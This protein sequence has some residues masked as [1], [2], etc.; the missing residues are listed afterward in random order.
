MY[1]VDR[2]GALN[3]FSSSLPL[4]TIRQDTEVYFWEPPVPDSPVLGDQMICIVRDPDSNGSEI[5]LLG[6]DSAKR[7]ASYG[8]SASGINL[9]L[10]GLSGRTIIVS[11]SAYGCTEPEGPQSSGYFLDIIT[12][13]EAH[14]GE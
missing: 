14:L 10:L 4:E 13:P 5:W 3:R 2:K 12:L 9:C 11:R 8:G 6:A 1:Y 7:L